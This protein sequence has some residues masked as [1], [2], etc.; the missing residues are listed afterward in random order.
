M[1]LSF[2]GIAMVLVGIAT[3]AAIGI[4]L[5]FQQPSITL[6]SAADLLVND[7]LSVQEH[8]I[9]MRV[10]S[11]IEFDADGGGYQAM[12]ATG[13][14]LPA[15]M[16]GGPYLRDFDQD[17]VFEGVKVEEAEFGGAR[18]LEFSQKGYS[19]SDGYVVLSFRGE[20]RRVVFDANEAYVV[21]EGER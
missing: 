6:K 11:Q 8:A 1:G 3:V 18:R 19:V 21:G 2:F 9:V 16:G 10:G 4:P 17:A 15:P 5:W 12:D 13:M 7:I 14:A 20:T